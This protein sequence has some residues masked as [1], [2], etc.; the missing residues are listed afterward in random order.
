MVNNCVHNNIWHTGNG[1]FYWKVAIKTTVTISDLFCNYIFNIH[2]NV[3]IWNNIQVIG[4]VNLI[5][6]IRLMIIQ[7]VNQMYWEIDLKSA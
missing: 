2:N 7:I 3:A 6:D 5:D 1:Y 4:K